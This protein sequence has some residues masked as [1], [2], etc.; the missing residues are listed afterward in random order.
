VAVAKAGRGARPAGACPAFGLR[1]RRRPR[2]ARPVP[3][4]V[5]YEDATI[6]SAVG[7]TGERARRV[8]C[9]ARRAPARVGSDVGAGVGSD[10]GGAVGSG[11]GGNFGSSAGSYNIAYKYA[12]LYP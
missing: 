6:L 3:R 4:S 12:I 1:R 9:D 2:E 7:E 5:T 10:F 8:L 11:V